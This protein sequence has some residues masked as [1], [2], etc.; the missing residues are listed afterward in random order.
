MSKVFITQI[1]HKRDKDTGAFVPSVNISPASEHGELIVM[2]PPRA[3]FFATGDLVKQMRDHLKDYNYEAGDS[4]VALGD[5]AVIAVA[6]AILGSMYGKFTVLK[7]DRNVG[8][9]IPSHIAV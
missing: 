3:A 4:L 9:Y 1:P 8:R 6:C 7:W 5:P 2:M